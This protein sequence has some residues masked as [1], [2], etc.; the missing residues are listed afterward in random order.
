M[1]TG[2]IPCIPIDQNLVVIKKRLPDVQND[3]CAE[4]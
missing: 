1:E 2:L 3:K 4:R